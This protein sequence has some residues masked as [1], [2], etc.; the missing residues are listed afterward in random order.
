MKKKFKTT[1]DIVCGG[2]AHKISLTEQGKLVFHNHPKR[3]KEDFS[4]R[5]LGG[6]PC[7]CYMTLLTWRQCNTNSLNSIFDKPPDKL[8]SILEETRALREK[9]K[10]AKS[11]VCNKREVVISEYKKRRAV[12][13]ALRRCDSNKIL[14]YGFLKI[15][16][17]NSFVNESYKNFEEVINI[18][19]FL[20]RNW[21][22]NIYLKG[23]AVVDKCFVVHANFDKVS[24]CMIFEA[25]KPIG[26]WFL[27]P[28]ILKARQNSNKE[29]VVFFSQSCN[30]GH[31]SKIEYQNG[32]VS[33]NDNN[34]LQE[35]LTPKRK[36]EKQYKIMC[37]GE[38]HLVGLNA[39]GQ[40]YLKNHDKGFLIR[41]AVIEKLN[42]ETSKCYKRF[43]DLAEYGQI[44]YDKALSQFLGTP[45]INDDFI[46]N[47]RL[48]RKNIK[49]NICV[50]FDI[51][52][53]FRLF[54]LKI[55]EKEISKCRNEKF[56]M[57]FTIK[58]YYNEERPF[59]ILDEIQH[60]LFLCL[61]GGIEDWY[62]NVYKKGLARINGHF[63]G[64]VEQEKDGAIY[65]YILPNKDPSSLFYFQKV[66]VKGSLGNYWFV[67][68]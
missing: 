29:W 54:I 31:F 6:H 41:E 67:S 22:P 48:Y 58:E 52:I 60:T 24:K 8:M 37:G 12:Q 35:F 30:D 10:K 64:K 18:L 14:Q 1:I 5:L 28:Y 33:K 45:M 57:G 68:T 26:G 38:R 3:F 61:P 63:V 9:R 16:L 4:L 40:I 2:E 23:L 55:M 43:K 34:D 25:L 47:F 13:E 42:G 49:E 46:N 15:S 7:E 39:N 50:M 19:S 17:E 66:F 51:K 11:V 36:Q 20:P 21:Y 59:F 44:Q 53:L 32:L 62:R 65:A 56:K 27:V